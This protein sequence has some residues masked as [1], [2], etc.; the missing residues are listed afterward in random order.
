MAFQPLLFSEQSLKIQHIV[1]EGDSTV[2]NENKGGSA[3]GRERAAQSAV[4]TLNQVHQQH[5]TLRI[6]Q[7]HPHPPK[8]K[9]FPKSHHST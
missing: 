5:T 7:D 4:T 3:T 2:R 1:R 6:F 8:E 9:Y